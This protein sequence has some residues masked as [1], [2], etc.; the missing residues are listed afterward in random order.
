M[1]ARNY[2]VRVGEETSD[3]SERSSSASASLGTGRLPWT[4][5]LLALAV[6]GPPLWLGGVKPWVVPSFVV[7]VAALLLR[8]CL[9]SD[10]PLRMPAMWWLGVLAATLCLVQWLP[11]PG[12]LLGVLAPELSRTL[13][14]CLAG[15]GITWSRISVVPGQTGL[16]F[17][18]VLAL[19]GLFIG[20]A[21]LGWRLVAAYV[22]LAGTAVAL[23]GLTQ[24]LLGA[25]AIYGVYV[26]RQDVFG[27]G[28]RPGSPLLT[29][30]VN[31]NHQ[32]GLLLVG[33]FAAAGMAADLHWRARETRG[34]QAS[35]QLADR[36]YLA[37]GALTIQLTALVLSMSR[38]ALLS[39]AIVAP[40]ALWLVT[41]TPRAVGSEPEHQQRRRVVLALVVVAMLGLAL[42]QG[43]WEQLVSLRD[44]G[45]F[46]EKLRIAREGLALI[47][48]SPLLGIG[49]GTFVDLFGL[50]D[51]EPGPIQFTHLEST[52][53]AWLV[54]WGPVGGGVLVL[55][56]VWWWLRSFAAN[57]DLGR[58]LCMLG[59]LALGLQSWAD[60][61]LDYLGV[62]AAAVALAGSLGCEARRLRTAASRRVLVGTVGLSVLALGIAMVSIPGSW[63]ARQP[64]DRLLLASAGASD[65]E[66]ALRE[67]PLDPML[68][69]GLARIHAESGD[70]PA[71]AQRA[72]VAIRLRPASLDAHVLA[73]TA[74]AALGAPLE[75]IEQLRAGLETVRE[76]VSDVLI[77]WLITGTPAQLVDVAPEH[78]E[79]WTA[80]ARAVAR[81][82]PKH[83]NELASA[84]T[85]THADEPEP[86]RLLA[87]LALD[88]GNPGLA[89]HYARLM[90]QLQPRDVYA[91]TLRAQARLAQRRAGQDRVA[92]EEL[93]AALAGGGLRDAGVVEEMLIVALLRVGDEAALRRAAE[94]GAMLTKRRAT[95]D[96][97][98]RRRE[99]VERVEA[100]RGG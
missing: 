12:S 6:I 75:S 95:P 100:A 51:S 81:R 27:L 89:L 73:A 14:E 31:A 69:L 91:L 83:A 21:Q 97:R 41:R 16:E 55:G 74:A 57:G 20:A 13:S 34:R 71:A 25:E 61:S 58:R 65:I 85:H 3:G 70:W 47:G 93:E 40:L 54:E 68:H 94:V 32:S 30:F 78:P 66:A 77:D 92:V 63:S 8:R 4:R 67:T 59:L 17:A 87:K 2:H 96:V 1:W 18:R 76:P 36:A 23:V 37:A 98:R 53:L 28:Q 46:R 49:R 19:T 11:L 88:A 64:R 38:A 60:F 15:T 90:V 56:G 72:E 45:S 43:A 9:R 99:L 79:A 80:L 35:E 82:S 33:L 7:V 44:P 86:L 22:S 62:S 52:P 26:P 50:V 84:R 10:A 42:T 29:S 48:L 24:K 39:L 5:G